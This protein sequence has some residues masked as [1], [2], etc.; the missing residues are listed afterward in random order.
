MASQ[1]WPLG[2]TGGAAGSLHKLNT[3]LGRVV[4]DHIVIDEALTESSAAG[5]TYPR[6]ARP[7]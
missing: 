4:A 1:G 7:P 5:K 6:G 2:V 3:G